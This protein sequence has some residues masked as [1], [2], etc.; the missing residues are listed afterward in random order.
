[1]L[2]CPAASPE[3]QER[4]DNAERKLYAE[5]INS[6]VSYSVGLHSDILAALHDESQHAHSESERLFL[7]RSDFRR[8]VRT[9]VG[10]G[11]LGA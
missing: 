9:G 5:Y 11:L 4:H 1:M 7:G 3:H 8:D 6:K 2:A 10:E